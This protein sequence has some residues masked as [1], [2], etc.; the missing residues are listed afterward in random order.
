M[1]FLGFAVDT[2]LGH[3]EIQ[4]TD[5]RLVGGFHLGKQ[6]AQVSIV[7]VAFEVAADLIETRM[8]LVTVKSRFE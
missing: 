7:A 1:R 5:E 4:R 6:T 2:L 3:L 8:E